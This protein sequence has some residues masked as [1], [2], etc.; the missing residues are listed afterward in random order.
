MGQA[1]TLDVRQGV[2]ALKTTGHSNVQIAERLQIGVGTV[3]NLWKRYQRGG[4]SGLAATYQ[5]C[6]RRAGPKGEVAFRLVRLLKHL[7]PTWGIPLIVLKISEKYPELKLRCIRRYQ[8]RVFAGSGKLPGPVLPPRIPAAG[9]RLAIST[10]M[11]IS[12]FWW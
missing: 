10:T 11:A 3:K 1:K 12:M 9:A 2:V 5:S 6:G 7:H 4:A 8:Q